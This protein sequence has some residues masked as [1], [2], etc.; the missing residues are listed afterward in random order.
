MLS[1]KIHTNCGFDIWIVPLAD[2]TVRFRVMFEGKNVGLAFL[3]DRLSEEGFLMLCEK[4]R[5]MYGNSRV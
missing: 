4:G 3:N 5:E 2:K 1:Q